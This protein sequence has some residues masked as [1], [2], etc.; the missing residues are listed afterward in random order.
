MTQIKICSNCNQEMDYN[1]IK[2]RWECSF[3]GLKV[4]NDDDKELE[5]EEW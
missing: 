2:R 4:T 5:N 1:F 3:C